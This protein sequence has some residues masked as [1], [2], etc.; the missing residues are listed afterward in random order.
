M[1]RYKGESDIDGRTP[2][3]DS[4]GFSA[5]TTAQTPIVGSVIL[6]TLD[7]AALTV[8]PRQ[9]MR[10]VARESSAGTSPTGE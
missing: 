6:A 5:V 7:Y 1:D 9:T 3:A 2:V 10:I 8:T 4:S